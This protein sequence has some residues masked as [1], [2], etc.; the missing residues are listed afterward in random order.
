MILRVR[1][2]LGTWRL[3]DVQPNDTIGELRQ[4]LESEHHLRLTSLLKSDATENAITYPDNLTVSSAQFK[5]GDLLFVSID[6]S[7]SG[8]HEQAHVSNKIIS[9]TGD[10]VLQEYQT[11]ASNTGFRPGMLPLKSMKKH[12]TLNEYISLDEQFEFKLKAPEKS[13]V[14][15]VSVDKAVMS[16]FVSYMRSYDFKRIR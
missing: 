11:K 1:T 9:K 15:L 4:R 6:E 8:A 14:T 13:I 2:A 5:N 7:K 10:I 16:E 12:W 3:K